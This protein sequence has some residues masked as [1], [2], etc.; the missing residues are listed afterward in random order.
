LVQL[1]VEP[2]CCQRLVAELACLL[3]GWLA[4]DVGIFAGLIVIMNF[5]LTNIAYF[6]NTLFINLF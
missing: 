2:P 4:G 1:V 6:V 5:I 3:A